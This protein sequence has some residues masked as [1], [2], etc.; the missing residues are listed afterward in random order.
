MSVRYYLYGY[1]SD[2]K[3]RNRA[4]GVSGTDVKEELQSPRQTTY[5]PEYSPRL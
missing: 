4:E 3:T 2:S 1:K 5:T